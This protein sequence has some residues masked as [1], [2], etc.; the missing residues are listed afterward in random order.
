MVQIPHGRGERRG[1]DA[2]VSQS[3]SRNSRA[4]EI[5]QNKGWYVS[6]LDPYGADL[7]ALT[8][9]GS[10]STYNKFSLYL[11]SLP[12]LSTGIEV[13]RVRTRI[14]NAPGVNRHLRLGIYRYDT[15]QGK[16][17]FRMVPGTQAVFD[18]GAT[19][20]KEQKLKNP[21]VLRKDEIYYVGAHVGLAIG[22]ASVENMAL[23]I[24][25]AMY[26]SV[27][28]STANSPLPGKV[29]LSNGT[30]LYAVNV[31]WVMYLSKTGAELL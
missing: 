17:S 13:D 1:P 8:S 28:M 7:T 24:V 27:M 20:L 14:T 19:G 15:G 18:G 12:P 26:Y 11:F 2:Y 23:R 29:P 3:E 5:P 16:K 31:P 4:R 9:D 6:T 25:P 22:L 10:V 21:A 30:K